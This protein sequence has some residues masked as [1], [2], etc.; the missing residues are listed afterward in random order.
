MKKCLVMMIVTFAAGFVS[1]SAQDRLKMEIGYNISAPL[2]SFKSD[3][4]NNTSFR[5]VTGEIS[6]PVSPKFSVGLHSGYQSYYQKYGRQLYKTDVNETTS[7][8]FDTF[9]A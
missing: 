2:G 7:L 9:L 1:A 3:Y 4:I 8:E 6:Y 5:G